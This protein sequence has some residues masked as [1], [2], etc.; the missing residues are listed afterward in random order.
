MG[1]VTCEVTVKASATA[2]A[3]TDEVIVTGTLDKARDAVLFDRKHIGQIHYTGCMVSRL[4]CVFFA[5]V[6][7]VHLAEVCLEPH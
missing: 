4:C 1:L 6:L 5:A 7:F 2:A 3:K